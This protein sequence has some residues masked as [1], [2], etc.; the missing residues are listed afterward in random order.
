LPKTHADDAFAAP[1]R[2]TQMLD[3]RRLL[4]GAATAATMAAFPA[5]VLAAAKAVPAAA[6]AASDPAEAARLNALMDEFMRRI[7]RRNPETAT[8]LGLDKG[9]L[10]WTKSALGDESMAAL[11]EDKDINTDQLKRLREVRRSALAGMDAVNFDTVEF[12]LAVNEEGNRKFEYGG[13]GSGAPYILSQL[14]GDYQ[15]SP[16]F[17]D[18][19]HVIETKAD[20]DAYL[21]RIEALGRQMDQEV[22]IARHDAA[23]GVIPPDFVIDKTL[24]QMRALLSQAT[25][26]GTV[27]SSLAR[28][29]RAKN[30]PGDWAGQAGKLYDETFRPALERQIALLESWRPKA[31]HDAGCWRLPKGE[32]YYGVSLK[33]YT[34]SSMSPEEVHKTGLDLVASLSAQMDAI[35]KTQ[36]LTQG[37]VGQ[38]LRAMYQDPK[39][40][41]PNTDEGKEKL[42][43]DLNEKV[44]A[45]QARLPE[46]FGALPKTPLEIHRVPKA[47]EAGAPGG[48]YNAG[49]L[50]GTRPGIYWINLRDTAEVPSWTLPTLTYHEGIPGHHLQLTLANEAQGLPLLRKTLGNSGYAEGWA[51]YAEQ[52][53][54]EMGM[55]DK[56]PLGHIGQ[57][58]DACFRAVR[59]VVDS[60]MHAKRWTREQAIK[61][62]VDTLG[63]QESAMTTEIERYCVWPGQA[64]SYMLG[65]ITFLRLRDKARKALGKSFDIRAFHDALLLSGN[66]PLSVMERRVDDFIAA[67]KA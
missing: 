10:A 22:E 3:R 17:L 43:A 31:V 1:V 42:I 11:A 13:I 14:T 39:Y 6:P 8:A 54:V 33:E 18:N 34:T 2:M 51:L 67:K 27:V 20:A 55:Y 46:S 16:D 26:K 29:T 59:L 30:I 35:M 47:I 44:K 28:R 62:G 15:G 58:H 9:D 61:Y 32:E 52:L 65:K 4:G 21:A 48:Y 57:L 12:N 37:T 64:C 66:M 36:G 56:D 7:L 41:Y 5:A 24:I 38:R 40:R 49:S 45:I 25:D 60:G 50:D 23:L 53:A 19:Q 63:D